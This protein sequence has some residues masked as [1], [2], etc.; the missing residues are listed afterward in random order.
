MRVHTVAGCAGG[1]VGLKRG[2]AGGVVPLLAVQ[3]MAAFGSRGVRPA[4]SGKGPFS[5][6]F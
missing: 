6:R 3:R 1:S 5:Y 4:V 2:G